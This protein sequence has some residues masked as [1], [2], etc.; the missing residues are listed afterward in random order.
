MTFKRQVMGM[1]ICQA[2]F[3]QHIE[4]TRGNQREIKEDSFY[5]RE[6][7]NVWS[8][9]NKAFIFYLR[10]PPTAVYTEMKTSSTVRIVIS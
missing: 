5:S 3:H 1:E 7:T 9:L 2:G 10:P 4:I 8:A 6:Q